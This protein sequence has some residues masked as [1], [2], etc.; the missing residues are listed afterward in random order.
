MSGRKNILS[1]TIPLATAQ[2]L[3]ANFTTVPTIIDYLDNVAYQ[4]NV[5]TTNST[6]TFSV[7]ASLDYEQGNGLDNAR[8]GN[9]VTLT[10]GGSTAA[11]VVAAAND[12]IMIYLNQLPYRAVRL[13]YA[14]TVAGTGTA[15][16]YIMSKMI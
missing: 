2:S 12:S 7:Q 13:S 4:I 10:L 8:T 11:P 5:S 6:G 15:S 1:P 16:I 3:A 9:W 14:S